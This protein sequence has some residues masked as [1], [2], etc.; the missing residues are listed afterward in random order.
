MFGDLCSLLCFGHGENQDLALKD[1]LLHPR[2]GGGVTVELQNMLSGRELI[3]RE[4]NSALGI[5]R[6]MKGRVLIVRNRSSVQ[7]PPGREGDFR[8]LVTVEA[9]RDRH[10]GVLIQSDLRNT[11]IARERQFLLGYRNG[12]SRL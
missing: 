5:C 12:R 8:A 9:A 2:Q 1:R 10:R 4:R 6:D 7:V 11:Q 3:G